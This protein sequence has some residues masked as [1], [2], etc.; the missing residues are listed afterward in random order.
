MSAPSCCTCGPGRGSGSWPGWPSITRT[1]SPATGGCTVAEPYAPKDY[2]QRI[3]EQ[4][5]EL[6]ERYHVGRGS[7]PAKQRTWRRASP[8]APPEP[9]GEQLTLL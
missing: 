1:W 7:P 6:A 5:R 4:V 2:Q 3:G 8:P 9:A